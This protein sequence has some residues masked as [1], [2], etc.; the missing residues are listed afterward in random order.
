MLN[1][2][3]A[4]QAVGPAIDSMP[5]ARRTRKSRNCAPNDLEALTGLVRVDVA[6]GT[7]KDAVGRVE[8]GLKTGKPT[9]QLS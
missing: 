2:V 1:L 7:T 4:Q 3:A 8:A 9:A 6:T 5:R